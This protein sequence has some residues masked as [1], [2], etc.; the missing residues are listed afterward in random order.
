MKS[1][2]YSTAAVLVVCAVAAHAADDPA[3]K[4]KRIERGKY[5]VQF[6]GCHDCHSPK[7]FTPEGPVPDPSKLLSGHPAGSKLPAIDKQA[8]TPG[9]WV[10]LG[11]D[12]TSFVGPW[13]VSYAFN[14]TPDEQTGIGLW[15]EDI[16]IQAMRTGKHMGSGRP[17]LPPMAWPG[18]AGLTDDDLKAIFAYLKSLPAIKNAVP[19]PIAAADVK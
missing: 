9:Y 5:M 14:L 19:A 17:I 11:P 7:I 8:L 10:L 12:F 13:G 3:A 4:Q 2:F 16:F 1:L 6:G 18:L 15:T